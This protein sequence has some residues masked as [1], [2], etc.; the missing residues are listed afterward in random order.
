MSQSTTPQAPWDRS[1]AA[2]AQL[3]LVSVVLALLSWWAYWPPFTWLVELQSAVLGHYYPAWTVAGTSVLLMVPVFLLA[4]A[5][6]T[7]GGPTAPDIFTPLLRRASR[8]NIAVAAGAAALAF[9]GYDLVES[10]TL[11]DHR[12]TLALSALADGHTPSTR[13]VEITDYYADPRGPLTVEH[14]S[15]GE[16]CY[17]PLHPSAGAPI[18]VIVVFDSVDGAHVTEGPISGV[19]R[20]DGLPGDI[21]AA[22]EQAGLE[23]GA[24]WVLALDD[25]PMRGASIGRLLA[26]LGAA[27]FFGGIVARSARRR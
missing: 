26:A 9:G 8:P 15:S 23:R 20:R 2:T 24:Y 5:W 4:H 17:L 13:W 25:S 21:G 14:G 27:L 16:T 3:T 7:I 11:G 19:L 6:R 12:E 1:R 10:R 18:L 22:F